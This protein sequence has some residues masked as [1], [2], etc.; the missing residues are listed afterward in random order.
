MLLYYAEC[1]ILFTIMLNVIM[2]SVIMQNVVAECYYAECRSAI[3]ASCHLA[4]WRSADCLGTGFLYH[5]LKDFFIFHL[6]Y[7]ISYLETSSVIHFPG[8]KNVEKTNEI[9]T[10]DLYFKNFYSCK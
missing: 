2:L 5:I 1:L 3:L 8:L 4:D 6:S 9:A 10:C 7:L